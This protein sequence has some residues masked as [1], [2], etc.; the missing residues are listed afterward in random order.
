MD[1]KY[2][3]KEY[4]EYNFRKESNVLNFYILYTGHF[5]FT[6]QNRLMFN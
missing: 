6:V 4:K 5:I 2:N 3:E 1:E